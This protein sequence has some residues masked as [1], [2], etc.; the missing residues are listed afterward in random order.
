MELT[1]EK[2][3]G[4]TAALGKELQNDSLIADT[5]NFVLFII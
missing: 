1:L 2:K 5:H 3:D 4:N